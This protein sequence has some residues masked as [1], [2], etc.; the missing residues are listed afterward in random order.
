MVRERTL[1]FEQRQ[2]TRQTRWSESR[3]ADASITY[4]LVAVLSK[5]LS[6]MLHKQILLTLFPSS[7]SNS[8]DLPHCAPDH[9]GILSPLQISD[10]VNAICMTLV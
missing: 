9:H 10:S 1:N 7:H 2:E 4:P 8:A 3:R 5:H 6:I